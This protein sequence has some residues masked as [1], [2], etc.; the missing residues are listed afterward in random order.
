MKK[1]YSGIAVLF[2]VFC[3]TSMGMAAQLVTVNSN[4]EGVTAA[5]GACEKAGNI[6]FTFDAGTIIRDGDWWTADLPLGVTLCRS[7]NFAV[8]GAN[9]GVAPGVG[10][11][12]VGN[13]PAGGVGD[14]LSLDNDLWVIKDLA[15]LAGTNA[16][17]TVT[18]SAMWFRVSG[19]AGSSRLTIM[20]YDSD[21]ATVYN[22]AANVD[23]TSTF[24]VG[25]D[26]TF[27]INLFD[28]QPHDGTGPSGGIWAYNDSDGDLQF[29]DS[30][31][32][33]LLQAASDWDNS[34]C[35]SV[36]T[37]DYA[38]AT[39]AASISSGGMSG[40]NFL[41]F[42]PSNPQVAH[43]ISATTISLAMCKADEFGYINLSGGQ[44]AICG[45]DYET[46]A[47]LGGYCADVGTADFTG[48]IVTG[49]KVI[50]ENQSGTFFNAGDDYRL[51]LRISGNGAYWGSATPA[52]VSYV[53]GDTTA[54][55]ASA[56]GI[57]SVGIAGGAW[58]VATE[59]AVAAT[60]PATG[61]GC[62]AIAVGERYVSL[63]SPTFTGID[64]D[65]RLEINMPQVIF[66]PAQFTAGDQV[67]VTVE[68]WRLPCGL[69]FTD[70]RTIAEFVNTC[71][72]AAPTTTLYYPYN[73]AL[74][75]SQGWW[76]GMTIGNP[77]TVAGTALITVNEADGDVGTY[78]TPTIPAGGITILGATALLNN[79]TAAAGNTGTL[80]DS[81]GHIVV[82]CQFGSA[83]GFGMTGNGSDSTGYTAYGNSATWNY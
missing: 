68:L 81:A 29:G 6:S 76:F 45:F 71:P 58:T 75:G 57:A 12:A 8:L 3:I 50:I 22:A 55:D 56:F 64:D 69:I 35:I 16:M 25:S 49:N 31:A 24:T 19:A 41:T 73:V 54:C 72:A 13:T 47:A 83:G 27:Q 63:T 59:T 30:G 78:T 20:A 1:L 79:L 53:S 65:Y 46:P 5:A 80:G 40:A 11:F 51:V 39:V 44:G 28:G 38:G 23:G 42:S 7:I 70:T 36:D 18:G 14:G 52:A 43:L 2:M 66:D 62:G 4:S 32:S 48:S 77:S 82:V 33:D 60:A 74:D 67:V 21:N 34:Y 61:V 15:G 26:A 9:G 37:D 10:G 17:V